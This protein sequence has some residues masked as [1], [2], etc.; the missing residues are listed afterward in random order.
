MVASGINPEVTVA[1]MSI[2]VIV[3]D[4]RL[5][6]PDMVVRYA[7][8]GWLKTLKIAPKLALFTRYE[9]RLAYAG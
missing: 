2:S 1:M 6:T 5:K 9:S 7:D 3:P 4:K 8:F